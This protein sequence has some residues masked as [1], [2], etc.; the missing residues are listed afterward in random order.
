MDDDN[1][2]V[3]RNQE[4]RDE[5]NEGRKKKRKRVSKNRKTMVFWLGY[6]NFIII[7]WKLS[8]HDFVIIVICFWYPLYYFWKA[9][10][11]GCHTVVPLYYSYC[12]LYNVLLQLQKPLRKIFHLWR[13][14]PFEIVYVQTLLDLSLWGLLRCF[15]TLSFA[16]TLHLFFHFF[17][18]LFWLVFFVCDCFFFRNS[19]TNVSNLSKILFNPIQIFTDQPLI[20]LF[21]VVQNYVLFPT[22]FHNFGCI[23]KLICWKVNI[24]HIVLDCDVLVWKVVIFLNQKYCWS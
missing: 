16:L 12:Y 21:I 19:N 13:F 23:S 22:T 9:I 1:E 5:G 14:W 11:T 18:F 10:K 4:M 17:Y 24:T 2:I 8:L 6:L 3:H 20:F 15:L 7:W